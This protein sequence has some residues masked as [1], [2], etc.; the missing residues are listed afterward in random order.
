M[1]HMVTFLVMVWISEGLWPR[2]FGHNILCN[3]VLLLPTEMLYIVSES[4]NS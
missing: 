3:L 1:G 4:M 2:G